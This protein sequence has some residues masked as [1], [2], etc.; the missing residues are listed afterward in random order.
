[1]EVNK[2]NQQDLI[3]VLNDQYSDDNVS[4]ANRFVIQISDTRP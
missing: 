2:H 3:S 1:M 4:E